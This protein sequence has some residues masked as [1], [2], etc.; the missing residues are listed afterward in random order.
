[1]F[2]M[3]KSRYKSMARYTEGLCTACG[4]DRQDVEI[5]TMHDICDKCEDYTVWGVEALL[6]SGYITI[7]D[8]T[9]VVAKSTFYPKLRLV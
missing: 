2:K 1:M 3:T 5:H 4:A 6:T 8:D 9:K 7:T